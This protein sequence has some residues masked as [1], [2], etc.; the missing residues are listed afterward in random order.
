MKFFILI[1][2]F[3]CGQYNAALI[4]GE[5]VKNDSSLSEKPDDTVSQKDFS[6][7]FDLEDIEPLPTDTNRDS[8]PKPAFFSDSC[9][10]RASFAEYLYYERIIPLLGGSIISPYDLI[11]TQDQNGFDKYLQDVGIKYFSAA[12]V[13]KSNNP[14]HLQTCKIENLL[15][16]KNCWLRSATLLLMADIIRGKINSPLTIE[17]HFRPTCYNEKIGGATQ[18][19]HILA[20]AIDITS[21]NKHLLTSAQKINLRKKIQTVICDEFWFDPALRASAGFGEQKVHLGIDSPRQRTSLGRIW[22]YPAYWSDL[23]NPNNPIRF[24]KDG[25]YDSCFYNENDIQTFL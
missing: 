25:P 8:D 19:D 12:E 9:Y 24:L 18:S 13:I 7:P 3:S 20:K 17:S 16:P 15:P 4:Q 10:K 14:H 5:S 6:A 11:Y 2:L 1:F 21:F 23:S 22:T